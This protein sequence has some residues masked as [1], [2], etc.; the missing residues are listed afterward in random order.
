VRERERERERER[1][2]GCVPVALR[3]CSSSGDGWFAVVVVVVTA[4]AAA[5]AAVAARRGPRR[6]REGVG[7]TEVEGIP[8]ESRWDRENACE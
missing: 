5:V 8:E 3:G 6:A 7:Q 4:A 2:R 1:D